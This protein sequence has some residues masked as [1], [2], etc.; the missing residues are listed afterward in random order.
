MLTENVVKKNHTTLLKKD[1]VSFVTVRVI[2]SKKQ[3]KIT[4]V[5]SK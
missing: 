3:E 2:Q 1:Y 4:S 5:I